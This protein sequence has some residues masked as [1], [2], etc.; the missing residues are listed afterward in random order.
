MVVRSTYAAT[1]PTFTVAA[2]A[3]NIA[4]DLHAWTR[5]LGLYDKP[6]LV[7]AEPETSRYRRWHVPATLARHARRRAL[8]I[9]GTWPWATAFTTCWQHLECPAHT[10]LTSNDPYEHGREPR[11]EPAPTTATRGDAV[12]HTTRTGQTINPDEPHQETANSSDESRPPT[13]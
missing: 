13:R 8:A 11:P 10:C 2:L 7:H 9:A 12:C 1:R 4:A 3:A 5:L 6:D